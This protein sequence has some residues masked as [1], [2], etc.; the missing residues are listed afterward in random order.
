[1]RTTKLALI[2]L[3]FLATL[4]ASAA[5]LTIQID[6]IK[7]ADGQIMI[8]L[9]NS[10]ATFQSAPVKAT[11]VAAA[12]GSTTVTIADLPAGDYAIALYHDANGNGQLD[13][14]AL[15]MPTEDYAFSN[16]AMGQ[17]GAPSFDAA[18]IALP[19]AGATTRISLR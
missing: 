14:N 2:P 9:F 16:N 18:R 19:P 4:S 7:S 13:R 6:D 8:A 12:A 10:A 11:A 3:L 1:M 17:R 15:G 5:D